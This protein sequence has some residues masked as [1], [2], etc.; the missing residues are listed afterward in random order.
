MS[1][2]YWTADLH[3]GHANI[4]KYCSRPWLKPYMLGP[5]GKWACKEMKDLCSENM[6]K[7]LIQKMN[8]RI[9]PEDTVM[10]VGD[11]CCKGQQ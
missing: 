10:H 9:K 1:K 6:N 7:G 8:M 4:A 2:R 5:D 3:L 11:F